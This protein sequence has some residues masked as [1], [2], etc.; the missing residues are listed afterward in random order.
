[1]DAAP[2]ADDMSEGLVAVCGPAGAAAFMR[3]VAGELDRRGVACFLGLETPQALTADPRFADVR[4]LVIFGFPFTGEDMDRAPRLR[5]IV[6]PGLGYEGVDVEAATRR[7]IVVANGQVSEN[8]DTVAEAAIMFMLMALYDVHGAEQR[9]REDRRSSGPSRTHMLRG[10]T[11]GVIGYGA[12]ARAFID[13]LRNWGVTILVNSRSHQVPA[14]P[15]HAIEFVGLEDL[16]ARSDVVV[17][18]VAL[19]PATHHLLDR[20][21]LAAMHEGAVLVNLSRGG[22]I[23]EAALADPAV[24]G[25]LHAIALDVFEREPLPADSPLREIPH[26]ILTGHDI[27]R[28]R[29]NIDALFQRAIDNILTALAGGMPLT[30]L[31]PD[32]PNSRR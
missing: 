11:V 12:I 21:R 24:A 27:A 15:D 13:R 7:G 9:L 5:A 2:E 20:A 19:V 32:L 30:A 10:R 29:E 23:E 14:D 4:V 16:L 3:Q 8:I 22:V 17:P 1:M 28:T 25:R 6:V 31:N 26:A 18:L